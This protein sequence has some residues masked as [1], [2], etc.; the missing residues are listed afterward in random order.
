MPNTAEIPVPSTRTMQR[1]IARATQFFGAL[2][3]SPDIR[4]IM[5]REAG[6]NAQAHDEGWELLLTVMGRNAPSGTTPS[7]SLQLTQDVAI[8]SLDT[9]DGR[10]FARVRSALHY[11]YPEQSEYIFRDL[12]AATGAAAVGSVQTFIDRVVA[13]REATDPARADSRAAD[14]QAAAPLAAAESSIPPPRTACAP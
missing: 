8:A 13:L 11:K 2:S 5:S 7:K 6:Y 1:D 3:R 9:W 14:E 4:R 12:T 10:N